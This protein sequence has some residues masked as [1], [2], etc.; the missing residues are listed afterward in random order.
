[1]QDRFGMNQCWWALFVA[2]M[3]TLVAASEELVF[4]RVNG[5]QL[6]SVK[7]AIDAAIVPFVVVPFVVSQTLD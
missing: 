4:F 3:Q 1:M 7:G 2:Q 5:L 6:D